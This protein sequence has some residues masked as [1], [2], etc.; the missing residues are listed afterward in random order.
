[1]TTPVG[2]YGCH[3]QQP[4]HTLG[5]PSNSRRAP[6]DRTKAW[7]GRF[8]LSSRSQVRRVGRVGAELLHDVTEDNLGIRLLE[9]AE[10]WDRNQQNAR[11]ILSVLQG[12]WR[13]EQIALAAAEATQPNPAQGPPWNMADK[14]RRLQRRRVVRNRSARRQRQRRQLERLGDAD[15][16][17]ALLTRATANDAAQPAG[18]VEAE[19]AGPLEPPIPSR[20]D[21]LS[22]PGRWRSGEF[23]GIT[24]SRSTA[25]GAGM[26]L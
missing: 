23:G 14:E 21:C 19:A 22:L 3:N 20:R 2:R 18:E 12:D 9:S 24:S 15:L 6:V 26:E 4:I 17:P 1:M 10:A 13:E 16:V 25:G 8:Y 7:G 11:R 5:P